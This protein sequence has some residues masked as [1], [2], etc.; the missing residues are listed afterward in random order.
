[1]GSLR[2]APRGSSG[3]GLLALLSFLFFQGGLDLFTHRNGDFLSL[4]L[5]VD[6]EL[7]F[8]SDGGFAAGGAGIFGVGDTE[9]NRGNKPTEDFET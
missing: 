6:A 1:M 2:S 4:T 8:L 3:V 7:D 9:N 5:T